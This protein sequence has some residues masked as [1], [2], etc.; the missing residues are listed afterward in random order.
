MFVLLVVQCYEG[1]YDDLIIC[2]FRVAR[3]KVLTNTESSV[4]GIND[5][6]IDKSVD[7]GKCVVNPTHTK[8]Y[9]AS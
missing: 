6:C 8:S 9:Y 5:S 3:D 4:Q 1:L 2:L 7:G